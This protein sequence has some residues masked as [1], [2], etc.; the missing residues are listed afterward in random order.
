MFMLGLKELR[1]TNTFGIGTKS[2]SK[3]NV[4]LIKSLAKGTKKARQAPTLG[5]SFTQ[6]SIL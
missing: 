2:P 4:H 5:V 3:S 1:Q 6:V